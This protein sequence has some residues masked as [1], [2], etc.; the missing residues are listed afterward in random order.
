MAQKLSQQKAF[1]DQRAHRK[2]FNSGDLVWLNSPAVPQGQSKKLHCPWTGHYKVVKR[3]LEAVYR[4]QHT[5]AHLKS[6]VA[7]FD[8]LKPCC[9]QIQ[10]PATVS[11]HQ[12]QP[13][14]HTSPGPPMGAGLELLEEVDE[15]DEDYR[16]GSV[17]KTSTAAGNRERPAI[18]ETATTSQQ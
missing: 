17:P 4:I 11:H 3:L 10:I 2:L 5:Q 14:M 15:D 13:R 16:P 7:Y 12:A 18:Q 1:Y 9:S 8:R 6:L